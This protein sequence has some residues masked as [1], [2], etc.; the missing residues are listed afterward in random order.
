MADDDEATSAKRLLSYEFDL[1]TNAL[2]PS[3][4]DSPTHTRKDGFGKLKPLRGDAQDTALLDR[5]KL[6]RLTTE[7]GRNI[8]ERVAA[9][10]KPQQCTTSA[11]PG[12]DGRASKE[13]P[14]G[15]TPARE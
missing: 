3:D 4:V 2:W 5:D 10:E 8:D 6:D 15:V 7:S 1:V 14:S 11:E 9:V 13:P 12:S